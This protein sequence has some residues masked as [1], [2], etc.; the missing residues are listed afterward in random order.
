MSMARNYFEEDNRF[1]YPRG[2]IRVNESDEGY[3]YHEFPLIY[4]LTAQTY[5]LTGEQP[6]N[7]RIVMFL[8]CSLLIFAAYGLARALSFPAA[9]AKW[10]ALFM[11]TNPLFFYYSTSMVPNL[12]AL[13]WFILSLTLLIPAIRQEKWSLSFVVGIGLLVLATLSKATLLFYG[14]T[15]A[16]LFIERL[17]KNK[18]L[19][20]LA[21]AVGSGGLV[22]AVNLLMIMHA[23][24]L[25][26]SAP[27]EQ[28]IHTPIGPA[29]TP[30]S[31]Y[32]IWRNLEPAMTK[33]FLEL[34]I[35]FAPIPF[36]LYGLY[37]VFKSLRNKSWQRG[38][39]WAWLASFL[40][41]ACLFIMRFADH[42]YYITTLLPIGAILSLKGFLKIIETPKGKAF[43]VV[44]VLL[45]P[46]LMVS[47][48]YKR[49]TINLQVPE[50][51]F[52]NAESF[53][54]KIPEGE[55]VLVV[56]DSSPIVYLYFIKRKGL[57]IPAN[58]SHQRFLELKEK[59][60]KWLVSRVPPT[61][62]KA[63]DNELETPQAI[64]S[65]YIAKIKQ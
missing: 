3:I 55:R 64:G 45:M 16:Y 33:W 41:F 23:K 40:I 8:V 42:A 25:Y 17:I 7:A 32:D 2:D 60:F 63:M 13:T 38:F 35:G 27:I 18:K 56:G 20:T 15:I 59:G 14:L 43:A 19:K 52:Y 57:T 61:E 36:F 22:I 39:W 31:L 37:L 54:D 49:W 50:E 6:A 10:Y 51:L 48:I 30:Q 26:D 58:L 65:F 53:T 28:R 29:E 1:L 12:P 34:F 11:T 46:V 44:L 47:R 5:R 9:Q 21:V 4:W 62:I 24:R